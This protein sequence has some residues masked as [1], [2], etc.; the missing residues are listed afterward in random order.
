V[1]L[2]A[3]LPGSTNGQAIYYAQS[4]D[5]GQ[6][7]SLPVKIAEGGV[8]WPRLS[9]FGANKIYLAWTESTP[10]AAAELSTPYSVQGRYSL[11]GGQRWSSADA[12]SGFEQVSGAFGL[13]GNSAGQMYIAAV[14]Q[15]TGGESNL[16]ISR[17]TGQNWEH[18]EA[19]GLAQPAMPGNAAAILAAPAGGRLNAVMRIWTL[20]SGNQG[21]FEVAGT[22]RGIEHVAIAPAPTFTPMPTLMPSPTPTLQPSPTPLPQLTGTERQPATSS[23]GTPP[24]LLGGLLT[25]VV[26]ILIA[27]GIILVRRGR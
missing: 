17:W 12:V 26:V 27:V 10:Q 7:W 21:E 1:W 11:D 23:Q 16:S 8:D 2:Q 14:G 15:G 20:G 18:H 19:F 5:Q 24:L 25:A 4:A 3:A 22:G 13:S 9:L 6:S